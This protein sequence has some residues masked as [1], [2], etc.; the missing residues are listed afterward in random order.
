MRF[1][2]FHPRAF[3]VP[4]LGAVCVLVTLASAAPRSV[5]TSRHDFDPRVMTR[6]DDRSPSSSLRLTPGADTRADKASV[7]LGQPGRFSMHQSYSLT[8][9]SGAAGS[10][11]AGVYLNTLN[12]QVTPLMTAFVDVGFHTPIHSSLPGLDHAGGLGSVILPRMGLEY[13]PHDRLSVH[14][15][16]VNG[17]DAWKAWGGSP[18]GWSPFRTFPGNRTP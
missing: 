4:A 10:A 18:Y 11:S 2:L 3:V 1:S 5:L 15:E 12:Y 13:R 16:L 14:F 9:V 7:T 6:S 8:A 17:P